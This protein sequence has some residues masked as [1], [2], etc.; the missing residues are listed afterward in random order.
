MDM[1]TVIFRSV[2]LGTTFAAIVLPFDDRKYI[3]AAAPAVGGEVGQPAPEGRE[4]SH[5]QTLRWI[6]E[7]KAWRRARKTKPIWARPVAAEEVG[8]EFQTADGVKEVAREGAWLCVGIAG[9]PWFQAREKLDAKYEPGGEEA[10]RFD[11]DASARTYREYKP[12]GTVRNWAAQVKGPGI[13]GFSIRPGYDPERPLHSPAGGYVVRDDVEDPYHESPKDAWLVQEPLF[14]STYEL[15]P[16]RG[17]NEG[18]GGEEAHRDQ[19]EDDC[20]FLRRKT[21][22]WT[23]A[24]R[25]AL[26][27]SVCH[28][29]AIPWGAVE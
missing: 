8:K 10:R 24:H 1:T 23:D 27:L 16:D 14:E 29:K 20:V 12:K 19:N 9:E 26:E 13:A 17:P 15:I 7:N 6:A 21:H 18:E 22:T 2:L 28:P 5:E 3:Q 25:R 11:F 4:L